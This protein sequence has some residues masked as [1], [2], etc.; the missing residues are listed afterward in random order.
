MEDEQ[1]IGGCIIVIS[2]VILFYSFSVISRSSESA[3]IFGLQLLAG[4]IIFIIIGAVF[5]IR[6]IKKAKSKDS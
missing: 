4:S 6:G 2:I 1:Y 5:L 3:F